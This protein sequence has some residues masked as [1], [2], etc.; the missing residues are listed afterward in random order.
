[1]KKQ[2]LIKF[3]IIG[4][5]YEIDKRE[6]T[7]SNGHKYLNQIGNGEKPKTPLS[8]EEIKKV[9]RTNQNEIE[10]L[11]RKKSDLKWELSNND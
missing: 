8:S 3:A 4:I 2:E 10:D 9:I 5:D 7:I 1:M 6:K 11:S